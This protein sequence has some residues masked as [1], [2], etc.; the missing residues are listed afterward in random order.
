[1]SA[2]VAARPRAFAIWW[3]D[4]HRWSVGSFVETGWRWPGE[5]IRPLS[6]ALTRKTVDVDRDTTPN[7]NLRLVTLHFDGEMEPRGVSLPPLSV[8]DAIVKRVTVGREE[9]AQLKAEAAER[10][11][12]AKAEVEAMILGTKPV[13]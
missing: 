4:L 11:A 3:R 12:S 8:Q 9:I 10:A 1:M 13:G 2:V 6:A 5:T 7:D